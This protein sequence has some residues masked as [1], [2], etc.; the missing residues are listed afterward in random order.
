[1]RFLRWEGEAPPEPASARRF[2]ARQEP[3]PPKPNRPSR[4]VYFE[5]N[6]AQHML[7]IENITAAYDE[8]TVLDGVSLEVGE[9]NSWG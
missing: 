9:A 4:R 1:M 8:T 6:E 7:S 5:T 2:A 3:R